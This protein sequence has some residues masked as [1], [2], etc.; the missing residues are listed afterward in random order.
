MRRLRPLLLLVAAC[1]GL[2]LG[3]CGGGSVSADEP[4]SL[5][6]LTVPSGA[7]PSARTSTTSATTTSTTSTGATTT[8]APSGGGTATPA[9]T[10]TTPQGTGGTQTTTPQGT[11]G[12]SA[13]G[14]GGQTTPG[15]TGQRYQAF[16]DQNPGAC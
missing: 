13:P 7:G 1:A 10:T 16:C 6:D 12:Q 9:P 14:A 11:G 3:S 8:P 4:K 5:P 2:A 15:A